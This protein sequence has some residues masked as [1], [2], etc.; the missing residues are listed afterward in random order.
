VTS[1]S[2]LRLIPE[3]PGKTI[4]GSILLEGKNLLDLSESEMRDLRGNEIAMI[5]QEPMTGARTPSSRSAIRS[6]RRRP[7]AHED[8]SDG[9]RAQARDRDAREGSGSRQ[10]ERRLKNYPHQLSGGM[11]Q[12]AMIAMALSAIRAF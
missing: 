8:V 9:R 7:A 2:I 1:L 5:F 10:P 11:R 3:P 4:S 12:R 6:S